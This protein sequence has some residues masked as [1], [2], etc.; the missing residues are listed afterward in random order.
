[1]TNKIME[2]Y[3]EKNAVKYRWD[4]L[5]S[6]METEKL[7][8]VVVYGKGIITQYGFLY[9]FGGYYPILRPGFI[10][11]AKGQEPIAYYTTRAD[12]YL[13]E[14]MGFVKDS[15][16][17]G[18]GDV[19]HSEAD[20]YQ[21]IGELI[22]SYEPKKVGVVG[23]ESMM[24]SS[25]SST[26]KSLLDAEV[27]DITKNIEKIKGIK[28]PDEQD[29]IRQSYSLAL[30]SFEE[31][32]N[33]IKP[34]RTS[35]EIAADIE[36]IARAK[37]AIDTLIFVEEGPYFLRKPTSDKI[38]NNSVVTAYVELIDENG[39]WVE[40][41]GLFTVGEV[42]KEE[43]ELAQSCVNAMKEIQQTLKPGIPINTVAK[44]IHKHTENL[45][46]NMGIWHGHGI[47]VDHDLPILTDTDTSL[48]E[49]NMVISVHPNYSD[50]QEKYGVS[51][52]D[53]FI[54]TEDGA[55]SLSQSAYDII[56][57]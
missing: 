38:T 43:L 35:A 12:R 41:G 1:M 36:K 6:L 2:T 5:D 55:E 57:L 33:A 25:Q 29:G 27:L 34:G 14:H 39:Y 9:Y 51:I 50:K 8:V 40:K 37:G 23:L 47:G 30:E 46:V 11:Y 10:I 20:L 45:D 19:I 24:S 4:Q 42:S 17:L 52:A 22:N 31:F 7:D 16:F 26:L 49:E 56:K 54:I 15:R 18:T 3:N 44:I 13:A 32:K 53:V 21:Q 28:S 48:F